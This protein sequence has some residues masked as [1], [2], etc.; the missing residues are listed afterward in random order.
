M[1]YE[2]QNVWINSFES[3]H[4]TETWK[5][6]YG[7]ANHSY[8][9]AVDI[10][11]NKI[12]LLYKTETNIFGGNSDDIVLSIIDARTGI[13]LANRIYGSSREDKAFALTA[14]WFGLYVMATIHD[15]FGD[16]QSVD[17]YSTQNSKS[18]F[19]LILM[20]YDGNIQ[21]I[22]SYDASD[23]VNDIGEDYPKDM[24]IA[25]QNKHNP[26]YSF[27]GYRYNEVNKEKGGMYITTVANHQSL[28]VTGSS[29]A[30][31]TSVS[32]NWVLWHSTICFRCEDGYKIQNGVCKA[33]WDDHFYH[34]YDDTLNDANDIDIW[35]PW[36][37]TCK[38]WIDGTKYGWLSWD[39]GK[40]F[41]STYNTCSWDSSSANKYLGLNGLWTNQWGFGLAAIRNNEC[42]RSCPED[43][44][45]F[46][47]SLSSIPRLKS[48]DIECFN[49][50]RHLFFTENMT[51][52][53]Y[54][55][56]REGDS[57]NIFTISFWMYINSSSFT[58]IPLISYSNI[59]NV[60]LIK[61]SSDYFALQ[62]TFYNHS[63]DSYTTYDGS[64]D[65]T[66]NEWTYWGVSFYN[67]KRLENK[68]NIHLVTKTESFVEHYTT[69]IDEELNFQWVA[70]QTERA[71]NSTFYYKI[72]QSNMNFT[73]HFTGYINMVLHYEEGQ[74][75]EEMLRNYD[76][77]PIRLS[78]IY[79]P[80]LKLSLIITN[81]NSS[82]YLDIVY[83][84]SKKFQIFNLTNFESPP[85]KADFIGSPLQIW[86]FYLMF[87]WKSI[88]SFRQTPIVYNTHLSFKFGKLTNSI[89]LF[90]L[91]L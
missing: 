42:F 64:H 85:Q 34:Q 21:E 73:A 13:E 69:F 1:S 35:L 31:C 5:S 44:G 30:A 86:R 20:D 54:F 18:N 68:F 38:T 4:G 59:T 88:I 52:P 47:S 17:T 57:V 26:L 74:S 60:N 55:D 87:T 19:A 29:L 12:Y 22:E 2:Y 72:G 24:I 66:L 90:K 50:D 15:G 79:E 27:I 11:S 67:P 9:Q 56:F 46:S 53:I 40:V 37:E 58:V 62:L 6:W 23:L 81:D 83:D 82:E 3:R 51:K 32:L 48:L 75:A 7:K 91:L 89:V 14:N 71:D 28:F 39:A 78:A 77:A 8:Y 25:R 61:D 65:F 41:D 43:S 76:R 36:H 63:D 70:N 33:V 80:N 84:Y 45:D 10:Y 16:S 49:L